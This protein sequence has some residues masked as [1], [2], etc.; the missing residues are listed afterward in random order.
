MKAPEQQ[1]FVP[2]RGAGSNRRFRIGACLLLLGV[3]GLCCGRLFSANAAPDTANRSGMS[4]RD[5]VRNGPLML[6]A[7]SS[8][9]NVTRDSVVCLDVDG[10][11]AALGAVIDTNG[12]VLSKASELGTGKISCKLAN[13]QRA[14]AEILS[15]DD[16]SDVAL[17]KVRTPGL[18]PIEWSTS[19]AVV[20]E[21]AITPGINTTPEAL[22]I[23]S[24]P[25][26]KILPR[27]AFIGVHLDFE[28]A[29]AKIGSIMPGLGA[30][31][32]GLRVG[33]TILAVN[34][35]AVT[36][37]GD[38][39][40]T[41][42]NF[43]EGQIVQLRVRREDKEWVASVEMMIPKPTNRGRRWGGF[44]RQERMNRLGGE[45]SRRAE[46]FQLAI[47]HDTVLQPWQCGGPLVN[48]DGKALGL[49]IAR[50]GRVASYAL[51]ASFVQKLIADLKDRAQYAVGHEE[52]L[53]ATH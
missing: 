49:N 47:Q 40:D 22:G 16:E 3:A 33:D 30:E 19:S 14:E 13:G 32:A 36:S 5:R 12:L 51:P 1:L 41:L 17:V 43:R 42:R 29:M 20:G 18:K 2:S 11:E 48:L 34:D 39:V 46:G 38:L 44:D 9:E 27:Q 21:W 7:F 6:R 31:K 26:R 23:V 50:A 25:A 8:I 15:E 37:S 4:L 10:K 53:E 52:P 24:V 45:L 28:G 35:L